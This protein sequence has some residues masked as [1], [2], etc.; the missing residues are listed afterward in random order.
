MIAG[1]KPDGAAKQHRR[2]QRCAVALA[3]AACLLISACAPGRDLPP[4]PPA[5]STRY[6][7]GPGDQIRVITF[8]EDGLSEIFR[9]NDAGNVAMPLLGAVHAAGLTTDALGARIA[10]ELKSRDLLRAPSVSVEVT[11]YRPVYV[12]GE[13]TRPGQYTYQPGMTALSTIAIAGGY[14]YRAFEDYEAITRRIDGKTITGR[15]PP[16]AALLPGDIVTVLQ[17]YF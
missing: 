12:L 4:L 7:L 16:T 3:V 5:A 8:G 13:V 14:T 9:V 2:L 15:A 17:R 1:R 6:L 10:G 11:E